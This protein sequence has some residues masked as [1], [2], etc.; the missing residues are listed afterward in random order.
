M[1]V[2]LLRS[3]STTLLWFILGFCH[4]LPV[5]MQVVVIAVSRWLL[6]QVAC[7]CTS[8]SNL[9]FLSDIV[10]PLLMETIDICLNWRL[11]LASGVA[12]GSLDECRHTLL[13]LEDARRLANRTRILLLG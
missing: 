9:F 6:G 11:L 1:S 5:I 2:L 3:F 8:E 10:K 12:G 4:V 7:R 13:L